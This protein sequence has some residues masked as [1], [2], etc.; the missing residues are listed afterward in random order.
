MAYEFIKYE[1]S[2]GIARVILNRP[3]K[4]NA[5]S[6]QLQHPCVLSL[7]NLVLLLQLLVAQEILEWI[8]A[9]AGGG[10]PKL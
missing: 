7:K 4:L 2:G 9:L 8:A 1:A 10:R 5:L 6:Q 3:E